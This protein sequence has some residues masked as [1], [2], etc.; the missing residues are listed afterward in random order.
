MLGRNAPAKSVMTVSWYTYETAFQYLK[1][2]KASAGAFLLFIVIFIITLIV[3]WI[4]RRGGI[5]GYE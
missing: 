5:K 3:L 1:M 4:F 2:G